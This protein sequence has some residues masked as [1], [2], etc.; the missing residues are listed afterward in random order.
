MNS[1]IKT[2]A[3]RS[4]VLEDEIQQPM[5]IPQVGKLLPME[6]R[7]Y[8]NAESQVCLCGL[9]VKSGMKGS[10]A[11]ESRLRKEDYA[12]TSSKTR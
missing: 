9:R 6:Q 5:R 2:K 12:M 8:T 3:A 11:R 10:S 7:A 1:A 4:Y